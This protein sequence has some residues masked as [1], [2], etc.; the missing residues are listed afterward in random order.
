[1][2]TVGA[3]AI[4]DDPSIFNLVI[5]SV[6]DIKSFYEQ[7]RQLDSAT[8]DYLITRLDYYQVNI[9]R[10]YRA[11]SSLTV[12]DNITSFKVTKNTAADALI[13][14]WKGFIWKTSIHKYSVVIDSL[15]P[16]DFLFGF[17]PNE[18]FDVSRHK[19]FASL[20]VNGGCL[21]SIDCNAMV[22]K[23]ADIYYKQGDIITCIY[24]PSMISFE[25][26]GISL[27]VDVA[28]IYGEDITPAVA[29]SGDLLD[30]SFTLSIDY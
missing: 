26:N 29:V 7:F 4:D 21:W 19:I 27:G 1:V 28:N 22:G 30:A 3:Y 24:T 18:L 11:D 15:E 14:S 6:V 12:V 13:N 8:R 5:A 16:H 17:A 25:L 23:V 10:E 9:G 20:V 2:N